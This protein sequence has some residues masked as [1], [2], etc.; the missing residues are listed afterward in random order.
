MSL[1]LI[2]TLAIIGFS[3]VALAHGQHEDYQDL[4]SP[5]KM[6]AASE[7]TTD[8]TLASVEEKGD[9]KVEE[10]KPQAAKPDPQ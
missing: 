2:A 7:A 6:E 4:P 1:K 5:P 9:V 10:S 8:S 3:S